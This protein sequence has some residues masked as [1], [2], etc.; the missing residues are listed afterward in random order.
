MPMR[1]FV[2]DGASRLK[3]SVAQRPHQREILRPHDLATQ[4]H[5]WVASRPQ[6]AAHRRGAA[7]GRELGYIEGQNI[8]LSLRGLTERTNGYHSRPPSSTGATRGL[9]CT[10]AAWL[11][12][13]RS[14]RETSCCRPA[15][16][17]RRAGR[18]LRDPLLADRPGDSSSRSRPRHAAPARCRAAAC[19]STP[20][21]A[22]SARAGLLLHTGPPLEWLAPDVLAVRGGGVLSR[23]KPRPGISSSS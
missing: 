11:A 15:V 6:S 13:R 1:Q 17:A 8:A 18:A 19:L 22:R 3:T 10:W 20:S 7:G 9:P 2:T 21:M 12:H 5:R 23:A 14:P 16:L 4:V